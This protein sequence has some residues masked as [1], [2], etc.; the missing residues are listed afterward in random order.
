MKISVKTIEGG[1]AGELELAD[2][3][4]DEAAKFAENVVDF[5]IADNEARRHNSDTCGDQ[6]VEIPLV[7]V[8]FD[9]FERI[10]DPRYPRCRTN[11]REKLVAAQV[12]VPRAA[13]KDSVV[14]RPVDIVV[15]VP[16]MKLGAGSFERGTQ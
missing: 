5:G 14:L 3:V 10:H 8:P 13:Q 6:F 1:S 2:A 12:V 15:P 11:P 4:L 9:N 16:N 7:A